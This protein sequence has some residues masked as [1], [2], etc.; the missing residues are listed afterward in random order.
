M[1]YEII[2]M[3]NF[4]GLKPRMFSPANLSAFTVIPDENF[5]DYGTVWTVC[6]NYPVYQ[7]RILREDTR[8]LT[9]YNR[10]DI[11]YTGKTRFFRVLS[12]ISA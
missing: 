12:R 10:L 1:H 6:M 9:Y 4:I 8:M 11:Y 5:P 3:K 2:S 7:R